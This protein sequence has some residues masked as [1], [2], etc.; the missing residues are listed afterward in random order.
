TYDEQ[1]YHGHLRAYLIDNTIGKKYMICT[2]A[3]GQGF[4]EY[5]N[6]LADTPTSPIYTASF[7][8]LVLGL[9]PDLK[10]SK[11]VLIKMGQRDI[12]SITGTSVEQMRHLGASQ[13]AKVVMTPGTKPQKHFEEV[14]MQ[15][16]NHIDAKSLT[17]LM[18][19]VRGVSD[20]MIAFPLHG[21]VEQ[22]QTT[23]DL[24]NSINI[25]S[26]M[27]E[28]GESFEFGP[29]GIKAHEG[30]PINTWFALRQVFPGMDERADILPE[31]LSQ[32]WLI[33]EN[34]E[35][36]EQLGEVDNVRRSG[37]KPHRSSKIDDETI[38]K[39][40]SLPIKE[41]IFKKGGKDEY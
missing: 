33:D 25:E 9:H 34:Y 3:F 16:S 18:E 11:D 29:E 41:K 7:T 37:V 20:K 19:K 5:Q 39:Y 30:H 14:I 8:K 36:I 1:I 12:V 28:N 17:D 6:N 31:G 22:R 15:D 23:K 26:Y 13:G 35:R 21:T 27:S 38:A 10:I 32:F 24:M 2:G 40:D 4:F